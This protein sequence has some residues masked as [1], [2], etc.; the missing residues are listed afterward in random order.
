ME[1]HK[2]TVLL[3]ISVFS[4]PL[5]ADCNPTSSITV[6][7][8]DWEILTFSVD[9]DPTN[10]GDLAWRASGASTCRNHSRQIAN[11]TPRL[12]PA[13]RDREPRVSRGPNEEN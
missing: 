13:F 1:T 12:G 4:N 6:N 8:D 7:V 11:R 2:R 5:T 9:A 3:F 10:H